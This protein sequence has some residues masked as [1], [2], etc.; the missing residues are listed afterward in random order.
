MGKYYGMIGF[1]ESSEIR[2]GV[3]D[4]IIVER[5]YYG[6]VL[7]NSRRWQS[8]ENL[9]DDLKIGN[10]FSIISDLYATLNLGKIRYLTWMGTRWT[11]TSA[12]VVYPRL[13]LS[14]G[15]EYNGPTP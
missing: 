6:D 15:G 2:P 10:E 3:W 5:P 14:I 8:T 13:N 12:E 4:D 11:V 1:A 9:N 7:R